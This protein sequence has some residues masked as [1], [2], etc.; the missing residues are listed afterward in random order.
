MPC[1]DDCAE[2][3]GMHTGVLQIACT[4]SLQK[5]SRWDLFGEGYVARCMLEESRM[6]SRRILKIPLISTDIR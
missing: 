2:P 5:D 1:C 4:F 6:N 3:V